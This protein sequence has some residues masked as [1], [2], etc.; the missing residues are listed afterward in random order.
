MHCSERSDHV[1]WL[2]AIFPPCCTNGYEARRL[3]R[4][5]R[6]EIPAE[7]RV[8]FPVFRDEV[9]AMTMKGFGEGVSA[10]AKRQAS[11]ISNAA[12]YLTGAAKDS[13]IGFNTSNIQN[14]YSQDS[15]MTL[16]GNSFYER[17]EQDIRSLAVEIAT[18]TKRQ[19]RGRGLRM[20]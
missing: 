4:R 3:R 11:V 2:G 16:S 9:G 10:E 17:D 14:T 18:L 19:Q 15:S 13:A 7:D 6:G 5:Q 1:K 12:R 8:A 20:A